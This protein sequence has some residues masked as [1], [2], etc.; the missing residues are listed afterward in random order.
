MCRMTG[1]LMCGGQET[2]SESRSDSRLGTKAGVR[3]AH[4]AA[5]VADEV[6]VSAAT[7]LTLLVSAYA[8]RRRSTGRSAICARRVSRRGGLCRSPRLTIARDGRAAVIV[9]EMRARWVA[10]VGA[11]L[12]RAGGR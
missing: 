3:T 7:V 1:S 11:I 12:A 4:L 6:R 10:L 8:R 2:S 9:R 5:P